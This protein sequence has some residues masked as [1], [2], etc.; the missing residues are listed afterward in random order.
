MGS[1]IIQGTEEKRR[2]IHYEVNPDDPELGTGGMGQ[3]R[4]GVMVDESTG[5]R[6]NVA[7]KFLFD[8]L[9]N[10]SIERARRE[11]EVRI[12]N[13]NLVEMIGF[14]TTT[15]GGVK[16]YHVVS[17]LLH[18]VML[19]DLLKGVTTDSQGQKIEFAAQLLQMKLT[20]PD[21]FAITVIKA[22]LSG[23]MALHDRGYIHRDIDPS[24]IMLTDDGKIKLIDFGIAKHT[25]ALDTQDH[26]L[27]STGQ[28]MGKATYAAPELVRGDV[29]YQN[30][31][32]DIYAIGIMLFQFLTG[33]LP[34][35]GPINEVL[36]MQCKTKLPSKEISSKSLRKIVVKATEK[37]QSERYPSAAAMRVAIEEVER[38]LNPRTSGG[39]TMTNPGKSNPGKSEPGMSNP[40]MTVIG[41]AKT[42][43][44]Q[45]GKTSGGQVVVKKEPKNKKS[46]IIAAVAAIV[47]VGIV[48][49][50]A[51]GNSDKS[52]EKT[53]VTT[54]IVKKAQ[55]PQ[56]PK[57]VDWN[58]RLAE[59]KGNF[60]ADI[61]GLKE[62]SAKSGVRAS[63]ALFLLGGLMARQDRVIGQEVINKYSSVVPKDSVG[64][65][66]A[67]L[68][69]VEKDSTFY[70][71]YY[72]LGADY[73]EGKGTNRDDMIA[74][75]KMK[76][77]LRFAQ[78]A[79]DQKYIEMF[80]SAITQIGL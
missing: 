24:N 77:G 61:A 57:D 40:G 22:I 48:L 49:A 33:K 79:G 26:Q 65:H 18:G 80:N 39:R 13:E 64:A 3:V 29:Y 54:E 47:I 51:F 63:E 25:N 72:E 17:E 41:K 75:E 27:T 73:V 43:A 15:D 32:T 69:A 36:E 52:D 9:P 6:R 12:Q 58:K 11:S 35:D 31:T 7:I 1:L 59:S 74:S 23:V 16:H 14:V 53:A 38:Q 8:D 56:T 20:N 55:N 67:F 62:A 19:F 21:M 45:N 50:I 4:R 44:A 30:E 78:Q 68:S 46:A 5:V 66:N 71:A 76:R 10:S 70:K 2:K 34:F 37:K 28:F 60:E 42:P